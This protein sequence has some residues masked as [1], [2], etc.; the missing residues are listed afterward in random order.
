MRIMALLV[1]LSAAFPS[2]ATASEA[3]EAALGK[4]G[5]NRPQLEQALEGVPEDMRAAQRWLVER[6]PEADLR[7]L[8][9]RF[10]VANCV[11]AHAAW[12]ASPWMEAVPE[13]VFLDNI[14][15]YANVNERRDA[16]RAQL[17]ELCLPMVAG[18]RTAGEAAAKLNNALWGATGVHYSTKRKKPD[19]SPFETLEDKL[20]S[21]SG[22]SILLIDA[23]RAVGVPARFV[24]TAQWSDKSGNHSWVEVWDGRW[25]FT[26][27]TEPTGDRLDEGWFIERAAGAQRGDP[28]QAIWA[29]TWRESPARFP[30]VWLPEDRT[31]RAIDVTERY[32]ARATP[33]PAGQARVRLRVAD[34][35]SRV[36]ARVELRGEDGTAA[37]SGSSKDERYDAND[38]ACA[39]LPLGARYSVLVDGVERGILVVEKDEQLVDLRASGSGGGGEAQDDTALVR[40]IAAALAAGGPA[41][42]DPLLDEPLSKAECDRARALILAR[43]R[44][45]EG[46]KARAVLDAKELVR[47]DLRMKFWWTAYGDK[48]AGGRSLWISMH[49][50]G[51]A[52]PQVNDQQWENQKRLYQPAEGI[53][54]APR[55]PTDT[56]N[57]WHQGHIDE[58]F[59]ELVAAFVRA[60]DVDPD[61]VY[62][63]GYS[64]GGD[65]VY[66]LAPRMAD[67]YAAA[68]MM[69]GHPNETRPDGLRNLPFALHMGANDAAYDRNKI[70]TQWRDLLGQLRKGD[71]RAYEHQV[72]I[73][74]GKGHWMERQDAMALPWMA[75]HV[76]DPH[77]IKIV[78]LQDDVVHRDMYWLGCVEPK[79]GTRL[80]A[81]RAGNTISIRGA[82]DAGRL[83]V[84]LSD[85]FVDLDKDLRVVRDGRIVHQGK[86]ARTLGS[87]LDSHAAHADPRRMYAARIVVPAAKSE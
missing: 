61:R 38:H 44:V 43:D 6:M 62:L 21:C 12:R 4:A 63:M 80:E 51:G 7:T 56:W 74:E 81:E 57:L 27:A 49:G 77:P 54:V 33:P 45:V 15:P 59:E 24:G 11:E 29:V 68:A 1:A 52:P 84:A 25:R 39:T 82:A 32:T 3:L 87:L 69:A 58:F 67:R 40:R 86:V 42:G 9:A 48:P 30:L 31:F 22:L 79:A 64:A 46:A 14:L 28:L 23:C 10:L 70:A 75:R 36:E 85:E 73:H 47:G 2:L 20:A 16:W 76:R 41:A 18:A 8:D 19:Q 13:E 53:Y 55:A 65:G 78:W 5:A 26:G 37:W 50:G 83:V 72:V 66:Q 17:R 60:E 34:G 71:P 35:K